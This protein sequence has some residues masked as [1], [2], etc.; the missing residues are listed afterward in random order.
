MMILKSRQEGFY[1]PSCLNT[2]TEK[3]TAADPCAFYVWPSQSRTSLTATRVGI[4]GFE[5]GLQEEGG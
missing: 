1:I 2:V 3:D 5:G 4:P